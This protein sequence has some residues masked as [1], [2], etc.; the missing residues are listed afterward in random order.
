MIFTNIICLANDTYI[1]IENDVNIGEYS[2]YKTNILKLENDITD[3][4]NS[5][6]LNEKIDILKTNDDFIVE[7]SIFILKKYGE[8]KLKD[9]KFR[10]P[11][12]RG[13]NLIP[14]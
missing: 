1:L 5:E 9:T 6:N 8:I 10:Q 4:F 3:I 12:V 7:Q 2:N 14:Y 13:T 11:E